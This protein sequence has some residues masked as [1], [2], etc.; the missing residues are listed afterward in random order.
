MKK[1]LVKVI[2]KLTELKY[3]I[4]TAM[5]VAMISISQPVFAA[6]YTKPLTS[7]ESILTTIAKAVGVVL[8]AYGGIRFAIAFQ[9]MDQNG[10]HS[11]IYTLIAGGVLIGLSTIIGLLK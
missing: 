4:G 8:I 6:S 5:F 9:K 11:A 3:D 1:Y 10:E 7:L 2:E